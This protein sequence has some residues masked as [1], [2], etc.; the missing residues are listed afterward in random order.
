MVRI[1][2]VLRDLATSRAG[3]DMRRSLFEQL[4]L[5]LGPVGK[6]TSL[7]SSL[8]RHSKVRN[9][10]IHVG[11]SESQE[12]S[13]KVVVMQSEAAKCSNEI[14]KVDQGVSAYQSE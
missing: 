4:M 3:A 8:L 13:Q 6:M 10:C 9:E 11:I 2:S 5:I 12:P 7:I 14:V 1:A